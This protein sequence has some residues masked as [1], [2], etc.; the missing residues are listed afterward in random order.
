[1]VGSGGG[2]GSAGWVWGM[3]HLHNRKRFA[4]VS[5]FGWI[6]EMKTDNKPDFG[7]GLTHYSGT[8]LTCPNLLNLGKGE[9]GA[10]V[11]FSFHSLWCWEG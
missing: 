1:M 3:P 8:E 2:V 7:F 11:T 6:I 10:G 5:R 9:N 4:E